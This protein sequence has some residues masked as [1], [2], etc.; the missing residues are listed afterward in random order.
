M[1]MLALA[2]TA[3]GQT[4]SRTAS[5]SPRTRQLSSKPDTTRKLLVAPDVDHVFPYMLA[6]GSWTTT[7][8]LTNLEDR[9]ISVYCEFVGTGG[10]EKPL[11]FTFSGEEPP[12]A[13]TESKIAKFSTESFATVS[14][15]TAITTAWAFCASDP[16]TER[17]SGYTVTRFTASNGATREFLTTLQP[18]S[19]PVFSLPF[20]DATANT[21]GLILL[22]S[23]LEEE[24]KLAIWLFDREGNTTGT[25]TLTL[26]PGQ[27]RVI[28][29]N[30]EF[31]DAKSGTVRVATIEG[32]KLVTGLVLRTNA[33]GYTTFPPLTPKAATPAPATPPG[34]L[35]D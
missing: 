1:L 17:F 25:S 23:A 20:L 2:S 14:T 5:L 3:F 4:V 27:L 32:S 34:E 28:V 10:E 30:E 29:L 22:N 8:Y 18:E 11:R 15:A 24:S 12:T 6:S 33:A 13:F 9:E 26:K 7:L 35:Q 21:T 31:K 19:E 16:R